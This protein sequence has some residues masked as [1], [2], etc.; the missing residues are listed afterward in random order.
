M[1]PRLVAAQDEPCVRVLLLIKTYHLPVGSCEPLRPLLALFVWGLPGY[2]QWPS[3]LMRILTDNLRSIVMKF[4][5]IKETEKD[6]KASE[7]KKTYGRYLQRN[8][9]QISQNSLQ[10]HW[11]RWWQK[12]ALNIILRENYFKSGIPF[13]AKLFWGQN[14]NVSYS[15]TCDLLLPLLSRFSRVWLCATP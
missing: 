7:R 14:K 13:P 15:H 6:L 10:Q 4:Q 3:T 2:T 12:D 11:L 5:N 8:E 1:S 9:R